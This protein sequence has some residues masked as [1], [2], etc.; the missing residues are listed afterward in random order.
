MKYESKKQLGDLLLNSTF[1]LF[2]ARNYNIG[3]I[4]DNLESCVLNVDEF[5]FNELIKSCVFFEIRY[6]IL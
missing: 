1:I 3:F 2:D 4:G 5:E 6:E